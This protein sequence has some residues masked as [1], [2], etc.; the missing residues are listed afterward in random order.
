MKKS[1]IIFVKQESKI[2]I[3]RVLKI[4]FV[5]IKSNEVTYNIDLL[6][7]ISDIY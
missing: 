4:C 2:S 1:K 5:E 6:R 3:A 7:G